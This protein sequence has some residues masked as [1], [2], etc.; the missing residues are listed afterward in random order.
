MKGRRRF[1]IIFAAIALLLTSLSGF[2]KTGTTPQASAKP[3][4]P[5]RVSKQTAKSN[6][7][8]IYVARRGDSLYSI[9]RAHK[10]TPKALMSLNG[11]S[12]NKIKVGQKIKVHGAP[13]VAVVA[14][15]GKS[16][17]KVDPNEPFMTAAVPRP[18]AQDEANADNPM[19][20]RLV[21]AGF[22]WIG[23][24]YRF[25]GTSET[26]GVD[27]SGLVKRLFSKFNIELPRSSK[28][29]FKQGEKVDRDKLE[30]GDLVFFSSGGNLP[31]HVGIYLGNDKFLHAAQKAKQVVV[32]DLSKFW[33]SMRYLGARRIMD[34]WWEE[35]PTPPSDKE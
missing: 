34:L 32:S 2:A 33:H 4:S 20:Y 5:K 10:T 17:P 22:Q 12:T 21:E 27:C 14:K 7:S 26:S 13:A 3:K 9:A 30:A 16:E 15:A 19:R 23:V 31:T 8:S 18:N 25:S 11:L 1:A 28:E 24:R 6:S 35:P 29:Q